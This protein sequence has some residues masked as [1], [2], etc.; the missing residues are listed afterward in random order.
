[1]KLMAYVSVVVLAVLLL[2]IVVIFL[3][4]FFTQHPAMIA[5]EEQD[6]F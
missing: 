5:A 3:T 2:V 4:L 1:M 6:I